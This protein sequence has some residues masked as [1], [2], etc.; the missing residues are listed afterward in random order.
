MAKIDL[1]K[2]P[3]QFCDN[4]TIGFNPESFIIA[5]FSGETAGIY[6][7]SPEHAKRLSQY[8][9]HTISQ[10]ESQFGAIDAKWSPGILSPI[11][12][13]DMDRGGEEGK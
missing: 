6:A 9:T 1:A 10:Y 12:S 2:V 11:Q 5:L 4:I 7:I 8:L 13:V 3:K